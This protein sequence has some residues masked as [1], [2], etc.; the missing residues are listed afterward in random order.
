MRT[1]LALAPG[2]LVGML[3]VTLFFSMER[4]QDAHQWVRHTRDVELYIQRILTDIA[5]AETGQRGFLLS[6]DASYLTPY[7]HGVVTIRADQAVL[8]RLTV[9]N[10]IQQRFLDSLATLVSLKTA[11]L[12]STVRLRRVGDAAAAITLLRGGAGKQFMNDIRVVMRE[13]EEEES[14]LLT[15]REGHDAERI[16]ILYLVIAV[17]GVAAMFLVFLINKVLLAH[18]A[19][20]DKYNA[21]MFQ[22]VAEIE[23]Q[24]SLLAEQQSD[25]EMANEELQ[26]TA[27]ELEERT[28]AAETAEA[29]ARSANMAK[30]SFLAV[31]SHELR[32]PINAVIGYAALL[33]MGV[34]DPLPPT[35]RQYVSRT[36]AAARHLLS[37]IE[38]VLTHAR[39]T[40]GREQVV[41]EL[42]SV[43]DVVSE[44][45]AIIAP[46]A[47][48]KGLEF[49][50]AYAPF[51]VVIGTDPRKLRQILINLLGNAIKF[52]D[53]GSVSFACHVDNGTLEAVVQDTG[54]GI[55]PDDLG[56][57]F[58]PFWQVNSAPS[59]RAAGSGL[60]LSV[61][62]GLA[63][64]LGGTI[65]VTSE[66]GKGSV[67]TLRIP[68]GS[69]PSPSR[70][71]D[72]VHYQS[73]VGL[74]RDGEL[75][76][77]TPP[78]IT[79]DRNLG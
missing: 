47:S 10:P 39:L 62:I 72:R 36:Q 64:L 76:A 13:M 25:L 60:G 31:M 7:T 75:T 42:V 50:S 3:S 53:R 71:S 21:N 52:T 11:E 40:A 27:E 70:M 46:L 20:T 8:R 14:R 6:G 16:R 37:L 17:G 66:A 79:T 55:S 5:D 56:R 65:G 57:I 74:P 9:D 24:S 58:D 23:W 44:V 30:S 45:E 77:N 78:Q 32:T 41:P 2:V 67:F 34:P 63:E 59:K 22:R 4:A 18:V 1:G 29:E 33:D 28:A 68:R 51:P 19:T 26:A 49:H 12:D 35:A 43:A 61:S 54:I 73:L 69:L 48:Q 38:E 15:E